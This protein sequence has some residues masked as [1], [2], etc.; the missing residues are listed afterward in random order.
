MRQDAKETPRPAD[1]AESSADKPSDLVRKPGSD[2]NDSSDSDDSD[3][4]SRAKR[5]NWRRR[6]RSSASSAHRADGTDNLDDGKNKDDKK[7]DDD[8]R[9]KSPVHLED[10]SAGEA[11]RKQETKRS[12]TH[13]LRAQAA[14]ILTKKG[15]RGSK[16]L[17]TWTP[18]S[19]RA[20]T[21]T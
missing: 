20:S 2:S 4:S 1:A 6:S 12:G 13:W 7:K 21:R 17:S 8:E 16:T 19:A 3:D 14:M 15:V 9:A 5:R 18:S 11:G 10:G